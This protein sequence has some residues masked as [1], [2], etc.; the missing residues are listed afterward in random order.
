MKSSALISPARVPQAEPALAAGAVPQQV[1][2]PRALGTR[3]R[4]CALSGSK[5]AGAGAKSTMGLMPAIRGVSGPQPQ[6]H[7]GEPCRSPAFAFQ[8]AIVPS[9][10]AQRKRRD[11]AWGWSGSPL[12]LMEGCFGVVLLCFA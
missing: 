11:P 2:T 9:L 7:H 12:P 6:P 5:A 1:P 3:A 10:W 8:Q 4:R